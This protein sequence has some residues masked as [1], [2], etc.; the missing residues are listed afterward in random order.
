[1]K[2]AILIKMALAK[3]GMSVS[4]LS[5]HLENTDFPMSKQTLGNKIKSDRF[6][7]DE[8]EAIFNA[9]GCEY[10][11]SVVFPDGTEIK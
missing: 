8:L 3:A 4:D 11:A 6:T 9:I 5:R 2:H 10:K 1:M 7:T